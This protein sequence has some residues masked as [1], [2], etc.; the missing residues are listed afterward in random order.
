[1]HA[2]LRAS[3]KTTW[4]C[5]IYSISRVWTKATSITETRQPECERPL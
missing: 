5:W 1:M 4:Y 3:S 2:L